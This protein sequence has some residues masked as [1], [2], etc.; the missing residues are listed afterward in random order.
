LY[1]PWS[2]QL[3]DIAIFVFVDIRKA[4]SIISLAKTSSRIKASGDLAEKLIVEM[5]SMIAR[6]LK[7]ELEALDSQGLQHL[8]NIFLPAKLLGFEI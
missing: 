8:T 3:V 4:R 2:T 5:E 1:L 7:A 6:G